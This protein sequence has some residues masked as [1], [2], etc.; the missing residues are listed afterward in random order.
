M[1]ILLNDVFEQNVEFFASN[2]NI[3]QVITKM[4][5]VDK[6]FDSKDAGFWN[7]ISEVSLS[8][9]RNTSEYGS[10]FLV[11]PLGSGT[12]SDYYKVIHPGLALKLPYISHL[13]TLVSFASDKIDE[14][15]FITYDTPDDA[16]NASCGWLLENTDLVT[17]WT[18]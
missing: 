1:R 17:L 3:D 4:S 6:G 9:L 13:L 16:Y 2:T 12:P 18:P 10:K 14:S 15:Y 11:L 8:T 5:G 7:I